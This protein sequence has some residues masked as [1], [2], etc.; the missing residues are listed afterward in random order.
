MLFENLSG[1]DNMLQDAKARVLAREGTPEFLGSLLSRKD[2]LSFLEDYFRD[3][4]ATLRQPFHDRLDV[5]DAQRENLADEVYLSRVQAID[6][7]QK[8]AVRAKALQLTTDIA[9]LA[10]DAA[11]VSTG[12]AA[13]NKSCQ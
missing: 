6:Q 12:A 3:D 7:T 10:S 9:V 13:V 1:V 2:W 5:L 4:F 11:D 8:Q